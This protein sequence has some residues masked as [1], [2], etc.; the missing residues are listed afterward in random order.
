MKLRLIVLAILLIACVTGVSVAAALV[1]QSRDDVTFAPTTFYGDESAVQ[2]A[3]V[4]LRSTYDQRLFWESELALGPAP[5]VSTSYHHSPTRVYE[6]FVFHRDG[7]SMMCE[8]N[9]GVYAFSGMVGGEGVLAE[10]YQDLF[11]D[12]APGT[13]GEAEVRLADYYEFYPLSITIDLPGTMAGLAASDVL[14]YEP[15]PNSPEHLIQVLREYF[16]IPVLEDETIV[17]NLGKNE[18]GNVANFGS[19][20]TDSDAFYMNVTS[21]ATDNACYFTFGTRTQE[22]KVIDTSHLP[23][24]YGIFCLPYEQNRKSAEGFDIISAK[25]DEFDLCYP[26]EPGVG[27]AFL[28]TDAAQEVLFLHTVEDDGY[29]LTVIDIA[30]MAARQKL[31]LYASDEIKT[32]FQLFEQDDFFAIYSRGENFLIVVERLADGSY[33]T[34]F[35]CPISPEGEELP[36]TLSN[37]AALD[38]DGKKLIAAA[39]PYDDVFGFR[40]TCNLLLSVY[41][42]TGMLY[43]GQHKNSLDTGFSSSSYDFHIRAANDL[44]VEWTK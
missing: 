11:N 26:L 39:Y 43:C 7:V 3:R 30:T 29:Y 9:S 37:P 10:V 22:G 28:H 18:S 24:G 42:K 17:L 36:Y 16:R 40:D 34:A 23:E 35:T 44:T 32:G 14:D 21:L 19:R 8:T 31:C 33:A 12:L 41:D 20:S 25:V 4:Q 2:G 38:F 13:E 15:D 5:A 6:D 1:Y 27:I